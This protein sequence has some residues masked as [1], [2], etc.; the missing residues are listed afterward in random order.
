MKQKYLY[1]VDFN[2]PFPSSEYGGLIVVIANDDAECH[3]ILLKEQLWQES[4]TTLIMQSIVKSQK[5]E[6]SQEYQSG[7]IEAFVT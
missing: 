4:Y 6:L 3:S 1:L 7:L 5:F 2:Q